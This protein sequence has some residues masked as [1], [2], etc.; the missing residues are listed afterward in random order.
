LG[1]RVVAVLDEDLLVE[2]FGPLSP[3]VASTEASP[4]MSRSPTNSSRKSRRRLLGE[5]E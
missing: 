4:E 5:R 1:H 3:T 2:L